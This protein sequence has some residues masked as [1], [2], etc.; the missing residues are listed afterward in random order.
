MDGRKEIPVS[1]PRDVYNL[2]VG[3]AG[4]LLMMDLS[5]CV[6]CNHAWYPRK[7]EIPKRCAGC[8]APYWDRP[9]RIAKV[10]L[11]GPV[12]APIKYPI[13]DIAVGQTIILPWPDS[14]RITSMYSAISSYSRRSGKKFQHAAS[15]VGLTVTR[16]K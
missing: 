3:G 8:G 12:G 10:R 2:G 9:A 4:A 6:R 14:R 5:H 1:N 7:P 15:G 16:L 11:L 13:H